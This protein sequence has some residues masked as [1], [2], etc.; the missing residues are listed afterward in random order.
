MRPSAPWE[1]QQHLGKGQEGKELGFLTP[2]YIFSK[3]KM[4]IN[5][6][7]ACKSDTY[8]GKGGQV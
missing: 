3:K 6:K 4:Q 7:M 8:Y 1:R 2:V 5:V